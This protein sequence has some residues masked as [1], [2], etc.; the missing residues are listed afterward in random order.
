MFM[1]I[2]KH[3]VHPIHVDWKDYDK[4]ESNLRPAEK[5]MKNTSAGE[6]YSLC[7]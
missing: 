4:H 2:Y 5:R 7:A 6:T 3:I 1:D